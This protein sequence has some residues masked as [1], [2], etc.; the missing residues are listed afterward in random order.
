MKCFQ[1]P[2]PRVLS[3]F[4]EKRRMIIFIHSLVKKTAKFFVAF[5]QA[6]QPGLRAFSRNSQTNA[7][8]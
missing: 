4:E 1:H 7:S 2:V 5:Y 8:K 3:D 6:Y